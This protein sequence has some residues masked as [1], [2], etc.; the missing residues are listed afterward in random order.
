VT[1]FR[2]EDYMHASARVKVIEKSLLG[3]DAVRKMAEAHSMDEAWKIANDAGIGIG[4]P[5]ADYEKALSASVEGAYATVKELL[6]GKDGVLELFRMKYDAHNLKTLVKA[7]KA[8]ARPELLSPLGN[9][10]AEKLAEELDARAFGKE[11]PQELADAALSAV[12]NLAKNGD[13][14]A[15]DLAIDRAWLTVVTKRASGYQNKFINDWARTQVDLANIRALVRVKRM[16][17]DGALLREAA[18]PGGTFAPGEL[19]DALEHDWDD[20]FAFIRRAPCSKYI[21]PAFEDIKASRPLSRFEKL[22]DNASI[23]VLKRARYV[24]FGIEPVLAWLL[25]KENEAQAARIVFACKAAGI[26]P[27][28]IIERSRDSYAQ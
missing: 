20:I 9:V 2:D 5:S 19:A 22:C 17:R 7:S 26:A 11:L 15:V 1:K 16:G 27:A 10:P 21:E 3:E 28:D 12:E 14:Q 13:P 24:P 8:G 23:A 6:R 18:A 4:M 25:A